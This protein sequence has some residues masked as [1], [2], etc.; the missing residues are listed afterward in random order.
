[1]IDWRYKAIR[2]IR[3]WRA[4]TA[5]HTWIIARAGRIYYLYRFSRNRFDEQ[6]I[7]LYVDLECAQN[8]VAQIEGVAA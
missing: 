6:F 4:V 5:K 8:T 2:S 7:A 3:T 1:M